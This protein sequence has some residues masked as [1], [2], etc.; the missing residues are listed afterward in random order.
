MN[1]V[2]LSGGS[3]RRLWPLSNEVRSK[4]FIRIFT[5]PSGE[6][7]SMVQRVYRQIRSVSPDSVVTVAASRQQL[8]ALTNQLGDKV[9][10]S[11]EP[12][13]KDTFPAIILSLAFLTDKKGLSPDEPVIVCPVD[14]YVGEDYYRALGSLEEAVLTD[15]KGIFLLGTEPSF[16]TAKYGYI[17]PESVEKISSVLRFKEKPSEEEAEQL[18]KEG[19]L[20]NAGVFAFRAG[21]VLD[22]ARKLIGYDGYDD[23]LSRY[24]DYTVEGVL[25]KNIRSGSFRADLFMEEALEYVDMVQNMVLT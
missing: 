4:Q 1:I 11:P 18:I 22:I 24:V 7:E 25:E 10:V 21:Y 6:P 13:R 5:S 23:L 14:P 8:S 20:W 12:C 16:P 9:D 17:I 19:A 15:E 2:L 3:G